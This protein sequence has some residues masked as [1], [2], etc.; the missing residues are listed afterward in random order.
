MV[1]IGDI[2]F[3]VEGDLSRFAATLEPQ[4]KAAV[5]RAEKR[6]GTLDIT[7]DLQTKKLVS[8]IKAAEKQYQKLADAGEDAEKTEAARLRLL[9]KQN[10]LVRLQAREQEK[11]GKTQM[12]FARG[13]ARAAEQQAKADAANSRLQQKRLLTSNQMV[14]TF[15]KEQEKAARIAAKALQAEAKAKADAA[16]ADAA[17]ARLQQKR[18]LVSNQMVATF[19][20]EQE[21]AAKAAAEAFKIK[22]Q[23][24]VDKNIFTRLSAL[25]RKGGEDA[26]KNFS[27]GFGTSIRTQV[28]SDPGAVILKLTAAFAGLVTAVTSIGPILVGLAASMAAFVGV[29]GSVG[30][31]AGVAAI[32]MKGFFGAVKEG[33]AALDGLTPSAREAAE[34]IRSLGDEWSTLRSAVQ[35]SI[36]SQ[37][38]DSFGRLDKTISQGLQPGME[39]IG[40]SIGKIVRGFTDWASSGPGIALIDQVM[41][42]VADVFERLRPGLQAFGKGFL[43]L[44][45]AS[46][47]AAGDMADAISRIGESFERWTAGLEDGEVNKISLAI[48]AM[49][50]AFSDLGKV[51]GPVLE[52]I[53]N[54]FGDIGPSLETLRKALFPILQ[55]LGED[56][57]DAFT[58]LGPVIAGVVDS[59][60]GILKA[61]QPLAPVLLPLLGAVL[62]FVAGG[63]VGVIAAL[64]VAFASLAAKSEPLRKGF[65][66]FFAVIKPLIDQGFKQLKPLLADLAKALGELGVA[67]G[68]IAKALLRAFGPVVET[69]IK[70]FF[71]FMR[72]AISSVTSLVK[73]VTAVLKGD[74]SKAWK[75]GL[76]LSKFFNPFHKL[77]SSTVGRVRSMVD[78]A[79]ALFR[80][81]RDQSRDAFE[82]LKDAISR[83]AERIQGIFTNIRT[84]VGKIPA[85]FRE[86]ARAIG[87][88]WSGIGDTVRAPLRSIRDNA[89]VPFLKAIDK[90]PGVP[91]YWS[92]I[93]GF[94]GGGWTGPGGKYQPAGVVHA[95]EY[96][97]QKAAR[98][99]L[100]QQA[101]GALD[102][103]NR[104]GR[105][106]DGAAAFR[107]AARRRARDGYAKGG[108][109]YPTTSRTMGGGYPGH[110]GVDFPVPTG[111]KVMSSING[112]VTAVRHLTY[113]YGK[114]IRIQGG[115]VETIY[116]HLSNT[117][118]RVGQRV[119][120]GQLIGYSGS[121]GNSTG[122]HLHFEVRPPGTQAGT[123]AWL[124]GASVTSPH[125]GFDIP[126]PKDFLSK[127]GTSGFLNSRDFFGS[128]SKDILS[129]LRER[130]DIFDFLF[131]SGGVAN[132]KGI[133]HKQTL[134]PERV[135]SPAQTKAFQQM[136][137]ANFGQNPGSTQN[138]SMETLAALLNS[139][140]I[141]VQPGMDRRATAEL[142]LNGKKY[143]EALA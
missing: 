41:N 21:K 55:T 67:L 128:V 61:V 10:Q 98:R 30:I 36:F 136:V 68:P 87:R 137:D 39:R 35:E 43:Q 16:K 29:L 121:T 76:E 138:L 101:P 75:A 3:D 97:V 23:A 22:A 116:A 66:D 115:G 1:S 18:L 102:Y 14:L 106:P 26:G 34:G 142:W 57:G 143:A 117:L 125:K 100:E 70:L 58:L 108:R 107:K 130:F 74:W 72:Q 88:A 131:D 135:L 51:F 132:G 99:R 83:R 53:G 89:L 8:D 93:P 81:M 60:A 111:T 133:M 94:A 33:G 27:G 126:N 62:A 71:R 15:R 96:V 127:L 59:F 2:E 86:T 50:A 140:Q 129:G 123:A 114:H 4:V 120:A 13:L 110:T 54:A 65:S 7:A 73:F 105:W 24:K 56:L 37:V 32:G 85:T 90:I 112:L 82:G 95:D 91:N 20:K 42:R 113:S 80:R 122:P 52:G 109:V 78:G 49:A 77:M 139:I 134:E 104:T 141:I 124:N 38:G 64:A 79:V 6:Y 5:E 63:P 48:A 118:A 44:F 92:K 40:A 12:S 25:F 17:N 31:A 19:R 69:Q 9:T 46:L 84:A 11:L 45:N 28:F 47:P 119:S 103:M